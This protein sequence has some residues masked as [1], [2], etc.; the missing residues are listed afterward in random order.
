MRVAEDRH[1]IITGRTAGRS[2]IAAL[3]IFSELP[4]YY[5]YT[6]D[7]DEHIVEGG[8]VDRLA[9]L[10][11]E[12]VATCEGNEVRIDIEGPDP[13]TWTLIFGAPQ[14][15]PLR[16]GTYDA[17]TQHASSGGTARMSIRGR[18][19]SC[20]AINGRFTVR[21][22]DLQNDRVNRFRVSFE[23]QCTNGDLHGWLLGE[24][25]IGSTAA[26]GAGCQR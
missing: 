26:S 3:T 15:S 1:L 21:E 7:A 13:D 4:L 23:Q 19:R 25:R 8:G 11:A 20:D 12:L 24:A 6:A 18:G 2:A 22:I 9:P 10:W 17:V 16:T 5:A 14:G